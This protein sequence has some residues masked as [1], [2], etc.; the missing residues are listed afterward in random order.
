[1]GVPSKLVDEEDSRLVISAGLPRRDGTIGTSSARS[2]QLLSGDDVD[3]GIGFPAR[4]AGGVPGRLDMLVA[5]V[6]VFVRGV[7]FPGVVDKPSNLRSASTVS[8]LI[9]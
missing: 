1:M 4:V 2:T 3:V 6:E 7:F 9:S 8:G 5:L